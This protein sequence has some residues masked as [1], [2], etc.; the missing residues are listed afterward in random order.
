LIW[1]FGLHLV[2]GTDKGRGNDSEFVAL[3]HQFL[4]SAQVSAGSKSDTKADDLRE[5]GWRWKVLD[6]N[7][8]KNAAAHCDVTGSN[9][10]LLTCRHSSLQ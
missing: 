6:L 3:P 1:D 10:R 8:K 7:A 9:L 5:A 4:F 2:R